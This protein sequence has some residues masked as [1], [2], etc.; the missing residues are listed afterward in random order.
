MSNEANTPRPQ[1][2]R[3]LGL[4]DLVLLGIVAVFNL[5][6]V[7]AVASGG[8]PSLSLWMIGLLFFFL[9][10]GI[11]VAEFATRYPEEGGIYLWT[12]KSFG[13]FHGFL[14]G[15]CYWITNIFYIPTLLVYLIGIFLFEAG[16]RAGT[17]GE[18]AAFQIALSVGLLWLFT[19]ASIRGLG[20]NKWLN[21]LGGVAAIVTAVVLVAVGMQVFRHGG[22]IAIPGASAL[23]PTIATWRTLSALGVI[24]LGLVGLELG[25]VMGDEVHEPRRNIP[26]SALLGGLACG[27][28]YLSATL[29]LLLALPVKEISVVTGVLQA[30]G[31]MGARAGLGWLHLTV[32]VVLG[33]SICGTT[34]AWLSGGARIPF[35][36]G[37]DRY[38]PSA[39]S[40]LHP[41]W[42]TPHVALI[43]QA[44]A[45]SFAIALSFVGSEV[46][47]REAYN[48]LLALTVFTQLVP[49]VYLYGSLMKIA[50]TPG[51]LYRGR[52][53]LWMTGLLGVLATLAAMATAFIPPEAIKVVW[54][55]E[56][57]L[58][59]GAA[60]F[61]GAAAVLFRWFAGHKP[62]GTPELAAAALT[63]KDKSE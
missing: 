29:T 60:L 49:F 2:K 39:F 22:A 4:W 11:A 3:V 12:K 19:L 47:V 61:V 15:W 40:R 56:A 59:I 55:F 23:L 25:S 33:I 28:L 58:C 51:G 35:V 31:A 38:L 37:L 24:C 8:F 46:K 5:N 34:S 45:S 50:G 36:A 48:T 1:L 52:W 21:N 20:I 17:L 6:I 63:P 7:P 30:F 32:A 54:R 10:Q 16:P 27:V 9:P 44:A 41:R 13:E 62:P 14:S 57:K 53:R 43:V 26:R 18:S 42:H